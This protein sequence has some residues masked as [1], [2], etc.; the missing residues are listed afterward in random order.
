ME[1]WKPKYGKVY[2]LG[3]PDEDLDKLVSEFLSWLEYYMGCYNEFVRQY[4]P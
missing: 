2:N 4:G 3:D 1:K